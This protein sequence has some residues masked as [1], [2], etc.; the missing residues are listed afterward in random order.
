MGPL[1]TQRAAE[2]SAVLSLPVILLKTLEQS[3]GGVATSETSNLPEVEVQNAP[4]P[5]IA[6][7]S[8]LF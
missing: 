5:A 7:C 6:K 4:N 1:I 3:S 2:R 8:D